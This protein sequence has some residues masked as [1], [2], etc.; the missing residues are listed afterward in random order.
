MPRKRIFLKYCLPSDNS[1]AGLVPIFAYFLA[2]PDLLVRTAH[3]RPNVVRTLKEVRD[4]QINRIRKEAEDERAEERALE[5]E[6]AKKAERDA[7]LAGLD[8]KQQKKY[9]EKE[10]EKEMRKQTKR[11]TT[12]A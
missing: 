8:A 12:R 5:R 7:K 11:S 2:L 3:F 9:L 10:R 4:R 6:R 1:Y